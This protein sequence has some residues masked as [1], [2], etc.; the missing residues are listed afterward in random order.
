M[1]G[2]VD[3][4]GRD[5]IGVELRSTPQADIRTINVWIG[6]GFTGD[7]VLPLSLVHELALEQS[8]SVS[9]ILADGFEVPMSTYKCLINWFG[10]LRQL[11]IVANDGEYALLGVGLLYDRQLRIDY[12]AGSISLN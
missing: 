4:G 7:I 1:N 12:R 11:E 9:A 5:L 2:F 10:E 6:T 8:G 3:G